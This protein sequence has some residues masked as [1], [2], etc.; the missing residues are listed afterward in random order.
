LFGHI[1]DAEAFD[2]GEDIVCGFGPAEGLWV[3]IVLFDEAADC[4]AECIEAA[5]DATPDLA[6]GEKREEA[7]DLIDP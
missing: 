5:V 4:R 6:F 7:F 1:F 3:C 2:G